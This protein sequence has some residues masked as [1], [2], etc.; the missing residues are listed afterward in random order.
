M[1][2]QEAYQLIDNWNITM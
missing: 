2:Q 1:E